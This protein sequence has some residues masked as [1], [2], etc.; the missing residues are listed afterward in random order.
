MLKLMDDQN[1]EN[2]KTPAPITITDIKAALIDVIASAAQ[3]TAP[4]TPEITH[5]EPNS[6]GVYR[7]TIDQFAGL[8]NGTVKIRGEK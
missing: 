1:I 6:A 5:I 8:K 4:K 2:A 7:P 3:T